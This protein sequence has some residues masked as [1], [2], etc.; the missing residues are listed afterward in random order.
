MLAPIRRRGYGARM[1]WAALGALSAGIAVAAG[2]FGAH[3][4][5]GILAPASAAVYETA[6]RYQLVHAL[7]LIAVGLAAG[8]ID[9]RGARRSGLLFALGTVFFC[10]SLYALAL[11]GPRLL[12]AIAPL[13]GLCWLAAWLDFARGLAR[14]ARGASAPRP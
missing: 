6:V 9:A 12:G 8:R 1:Q 11:G 7:A 3:A 5:R 2:A 14:A 13:G 10:G 4:L